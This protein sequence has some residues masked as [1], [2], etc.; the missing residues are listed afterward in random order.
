MVGSAGKATTN[1]QAA[2][3]FEYRPRMGIVAAETAN[4]YIFAPED[5]SDKTFVAPLSA[6]F[7][8]A[9]SLAPKLSIETG[10]TYTYL[11]TLFKNNQI[12]AKLHL[13]YLGIPLRFVYDFSKNN[14]WTFYTSAGGMIEKGLW[15]VYVQ[16]QNF[17]NS[18]ITTT[19]T[20]KIQ[21]FQF[22]VNSSVCGA[23]SIYKNASVYFEPKISYYFENNQPI[24]IRS[25][26]SLVIGFEG[27]LRY[28]F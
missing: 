6:G 4:T 20:D 7:A 10:V 2:P 26:N 15:S 3:V 11:L 27:G 22:S 17:T 23:Y 25:E 19:V 18:L 24:S 21:G 5:F 13:H 9:R 14:K 8:V 12:D 28:K 1:A 16:N